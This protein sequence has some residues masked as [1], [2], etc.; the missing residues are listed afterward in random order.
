M[1]FVA[2][3]TAGL[4]GAGAQYIC[5]PVRTRR[6][7]RT[8]AQRLPEITAVLTMFQTTMSLSYPLVQTSCRCPI[9]GVGA[10]M[11]QRRANLVATRIGANNVHTAM[12]DE[13]YFAT[14]GGPGRPTSV[15][16]GA[17]RSP[18]AYPCHRPDALLPLLEDP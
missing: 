6:N 18:V 15:G 1:E 3:C 7:G 10:Q 2:C 17:T 13:Q 11:L 12:P 14:G 16:T 5:A 8:G 4:P 9:L